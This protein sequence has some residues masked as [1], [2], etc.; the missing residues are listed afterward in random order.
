M[1]LS[2][3]MTFHTI[4]LHPIRNM[5]H[6]LSTIPRLYLLPSHYYRKK[7]IV[8]IGFGTLSGF[9]ASTRG[10]GRYLAPSQHSTNVVAVAPATVPIAATEVLSR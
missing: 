3:V 10:L 9:R 6:P 5:N 7:N 2:S 1:I 8:Y 4:L